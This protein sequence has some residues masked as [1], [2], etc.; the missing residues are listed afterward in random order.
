MLEADGLGGR[1][2]SRARSGRVPAEGPEL[3]PAAGKPRVPGPPAGR[4]QHNIAK[5]IAVPLA[6]TRFNGYGMLRTVLS[7][8]SRVTS[9]GKTRSL[10]CL[11]H[12]AGHGQRAAESAPMPP[13][14]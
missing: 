9:A 8:L 11:A 10:S 1:V 14:P 4:Y 12:L 2:G 6:A 5:H 13:S 3:A 7:T